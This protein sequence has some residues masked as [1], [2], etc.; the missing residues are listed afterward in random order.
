MTSHAGGV[1]LRYHMILNTALPQGAAI[2]MITCD[3]LMAQQ[4]Y[5]C[6]PAQRFVARAGGNLDSW[7]AVSAACMWT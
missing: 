6:S 7:Q 5:S 4:P 1:S 3:G 2:P